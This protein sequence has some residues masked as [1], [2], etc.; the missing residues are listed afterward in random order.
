[1]PGNHMGAEYPSLG[2]A[3]D[4]DECHDSAN[5]YYYD[6]VRKQEDIQER[7]DNASKKLTQEIK[8]FKKKML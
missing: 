3:A 6:L 8:K 1:M 4:D 5:N 2:R 7:I